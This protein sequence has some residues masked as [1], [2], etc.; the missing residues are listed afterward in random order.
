M[1]FKDKLLNFIKTSN[2]NPI[3]ISIAAKP[4]IKKVSEN[5]DK[6]STTTLNIAERL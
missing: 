4:R 6:S 1:K 3:E 2:S 5:N